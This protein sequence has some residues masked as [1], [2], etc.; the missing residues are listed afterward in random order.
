MVGHVAATATHIAGDYP[1]LFDG[2]LAH[3]DF[4]LVRFD[5]DQD[6]FPDS[7]DECDGWIVTP[8]RCSVTDAALLD[9]QRRGFRAANCWTGSDRTW[10]SAS[11]ISW[12]RRHSGHPSCVRRPAGRSA[13]TTT[14]SSPGR[15]GWSRPRST[16]HLIASHEDQV[17]A[18][19]DGAELLATTPGCPVAGLLIGDRAWTL[20][21]HPEFTP[22][23][24]DELLGQRETLIGPTKVATARATLSQRPDAA[25]VGS[26]IGAFFALTRRR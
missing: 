15:R 17:T 16:S 3:A 20:Q 12:W 22:P 8:S 2:L 6:R 21:P 10:A 26:W 18:V 5:L 4:D 23:L 24:A 25:T 14:R 13:S 1:E 7:V 11:V 9:R 19:P